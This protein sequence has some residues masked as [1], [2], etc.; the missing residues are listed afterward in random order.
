MDPTKVLNQMYETVKKT[1][2]SVT[3]PD[4]IGATV[5]KMKAM[6]DSIVKMGLD[7]AKTV[8]NGSG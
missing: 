6:G 5:E 8:T 2:D 4:K 3:S 1:I 7:F